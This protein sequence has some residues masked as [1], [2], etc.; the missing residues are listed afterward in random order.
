M[1][2]PEELEE[3]RRRARERARALRPTVPSPALELSVMPTSAAPSGAVP[4]TAVPWATP[5]NIQPSAVGTTTQRAGPTTLAT[6][7]APHEVTPGGASAELVRRRQQLAASTGA[8][9]LP[10]DLGALTPEGPYTKQYPAPGAPLPAPPAPPAGGPGGGLSP[11]TVDWLELGFGSQEEGANWANAFAREHGGLMPWEA[12]E[13][14]PISNMEEHL[15]ALT[16][17]RG[18]A[19]KQGRSPSMRD[20]ERQYFSNRFGLGWGR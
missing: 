9:Q 4:R 13:R 3:L 7:G 12:G 5:A 18:F 2:T 20:Y 15:A 19:E 11:E 6:Q 8:G 1:A 16:W 17:S 10:T 14:D